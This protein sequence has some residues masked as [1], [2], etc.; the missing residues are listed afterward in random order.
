MSDW[1]DDLLDALDRIATEIP[2][3]GWY[4]YAI[5]RAK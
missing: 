3:Y 2:D 5:A 4:I 1:P